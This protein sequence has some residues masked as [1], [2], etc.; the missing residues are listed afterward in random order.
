MP[1]LDRRQAEYRA[2][3]V[4]QYERLVTESMEALAAR[5]VPALE[6]DL[7][8]PTTSPAAGSY[9]PGAGAVLL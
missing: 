9:S 7:G 3:L 1:E 4:A 6:L 2:A 8:P 5:R